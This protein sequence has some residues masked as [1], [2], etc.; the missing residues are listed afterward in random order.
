M[1][2]C[3][4][5]Y[6]HIHFIISPIHN[7]LGREWLGIWHFRRATVEE[8]SGCSAYVLCFHSGALHLKGYPS[9]LKFFFKSQGEYM[10]EESKPH[11][12]RN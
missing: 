5:L 4:Y 7:S 12:R 6:V 2:A 10:I 3:A 11:P 9:P 8:V 1:Y